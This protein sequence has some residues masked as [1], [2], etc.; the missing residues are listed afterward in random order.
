[1]SRELGVQFARQGVRVNA[2]CPGPVNTPL[3]EELFAKDPERAGRRLVHIPMGRFGEAAEIAAAAA[4]L[5]S[6]DS[7]FIT[8]RPSWSTAAS[9]GPTSRPR[10]HPLRADDRDGNRPR[11]SPHRGSAVAPGF[12]DGPQWADGDGR[13]GRGGGTLPDGVRLSP[14]APDRLSAG[15]PRS[16]APAAARDRRKLPHLDPGHAAAAARLHRAGA[17]LLRS[18]RIGQTS[19]RLLARQPGGQRARP[20]APA[21]HRAGHRRRPGPTGAVSRC[22][23]RTGIPRAL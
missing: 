1:M 10:R 6:D 4:F 9:P 17:R 5:A 15:G 21:R 16:G 2:L 20:A 7:S 11:T 19:R 12:G 13:F 22:S 8:R 3:L 14:R 23:S 18:R